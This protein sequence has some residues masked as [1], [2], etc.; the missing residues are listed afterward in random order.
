MQALLTSRA[1]GWY[2]LLI[3]V[4]PEAPGR[5]LQ[6]EPAQG[7][8]W[9]RRVEREREAQGE[10]VR[11]AAWG[12]RAP[13]KEPVIRAEAR[14]WA[15]PAQVGEAAAAPWVE[16]R[17]QVEWE[18]EQDLAVRA[19]VPVQAAEADRTSGFLTALQEA[20]AR[21]GKNSSVRCNTIGRVAL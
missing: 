14:T 10:R 15:A 2:W 8:A 3:R 13:L 17:V 16:E 18:E 21:Q 20:F 5:D 4:D 11:A 12:P 19:A 7:A 1:P 9:A 6:V